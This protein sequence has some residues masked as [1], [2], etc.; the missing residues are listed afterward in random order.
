VRKFA[1]FEL[2]AS[3]QGSA[4][5]PGEPSGAT[6]V[7]VWLR[8]A[9]V[10]PRS[11]CPQQADRSRENDGNQKLHRAYSAERAHQD[12][13]G[14]GDSNE[15]SEAVQSAHLS[16]SL[17]NRPV[18]AQ[19]EAPCTVIWLL[20]DTSNLGRRWVATRLLP[21]TVVRKFAPF[22][23][24]ASIKVRYRFGQMIADGDEFVRAQRELADD[25][26]FESFEQAL[27]SWIASVAI[28]EV[29]YVGVWEEYAHEL[30]AR[31][32]L[33]ELSRRAPRWWAK[34]I[35]KQVAPWDERFRAATEQTEKAQLIPEDGN[36][37]WRQF[38]VPRR[39]EEP[40]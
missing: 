28:I 33:E 21:R 3:I 30:M 8:C 18:R 32:Y 29:G 22:E 36:P 5:V 9:P 12:D 7:S 34:D 26:G 23:P 20:L 14:N 1:P 24:S 35:A 39:W 2:S 37:G 6:A 38:R 13:Q 4:A 19:V 27:R 40:G 10:P 11:I 25:W 31:D 16:S 15:Q 17:A